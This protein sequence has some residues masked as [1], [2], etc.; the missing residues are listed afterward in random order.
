MVPLCHMSQEAV[1]MRMFSGVFSVL[2]VAGLASAVPQGPTWADETQTYRFTASVLG[3]T[4]GKMT[5]AVNRK[6]TTYAVTGNTSSAG[7]GGLFRSFSVTSKVRGTEIDGQFRPERYQSTSEGERAGRGAEMVYKGGVP[8]ILS[9]AA[10]ERPGAPVLDPAKQ[11]GTV[12]PLSMTYALLR[13]IDRDRACTLNLKV[14][15]GHRLSHVSLGQPQPDGEGLVCTGLYRRLD[16]YPAE[17]I[18]ERQDFPFTI[19]YTP[20]PDG[21]LQ[22][23]EIVLDSLFG[24]ARLSRME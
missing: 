23:T 17:E 5:M 16:G 12:D 15:D 4:A 13:D 8:E 6:G 10:E 14:F 7:M 21:Q 11:A 24:V 9:L 3:V 1:K 19:A 22:V 2:L 18:A 20:G